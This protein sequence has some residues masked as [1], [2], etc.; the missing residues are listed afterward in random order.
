MKRL[1][2]IGILVAP[3]S[4]LLQR[5][6]KNLRRKCE[7]SSKPKL[8]RAGDAALAKYK[9]LFDY[10]TEVLENEHE[11]FKNADEKASKYTTILTFLLGVVAYV[12]KWTMEHAIPAHNAID[13]A[14]IIDGAATLV[15]AVISWFL[16]SRV[17]TSSSYRGRP[18][19]D[20]VLSFYRN[21]RLIDIYYA[22]AKANAKALDEN[23]KK[24]ARK[25]RT[26]IVAFRWMYAAAI[27]LLLL[28][29]LFCWKLWEKSLNLDER[30]PYSLVTSNNQYR[31]LKEVKLWTDLQILSEDENLRSR[32]GRP[33]RATQN[34][35]T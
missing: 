3:L 22:F 32:A 34:S 7:E 17:I 26:L 2:A 15:C 6:A 5:I 19:N 21:N 33:S 14:L 24:T 9:E 11:R 12:D 27:G 30:V 25:Y 18:L 28:L 4:L 8:E 16:V 10:S 23:S 20:E 29:G 13:W 35:Q 31:S 1:L